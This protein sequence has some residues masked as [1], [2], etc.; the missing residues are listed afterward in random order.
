H[1]KENGKQLDDVDLDDPD[2][3]LDVEN[4]I[5][6][7]EEDFGRLLKKKKANKAKNAKLAKEEK[8]AKNAKLAKEAKKA[9]LK[10]NEAMLVEVV[11]VSSDEDDS[12]GEG[13]FGDECRISYFTAR[14]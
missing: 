2:D 6:K 13:L 12:S 8:K 5:K 9:E 10:A 4:I 1:D 3:A 7:L 11:Q 14:R